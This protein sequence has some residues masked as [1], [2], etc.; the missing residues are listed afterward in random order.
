MNTE[1]QLTWQDIKQI[2][3]I[4]DDLIP[5]TPFVSVS[6]QIFA[7]E[8]QTE[9]SYYTEILKRFNGQK[10]KSY[11]PSWEDKEYVEVASGYLVTESDELKYV[12]DNAIFNAARNKI[13]HNIAY[14]LVHKFPDPDVEEDPFGRRKYSYRFQVRRQ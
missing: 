2:V 9:E 6:E 14:D 3:N 4:A 10:K 5:C 1:T 13:A 12:G 11:E 7:D 8:F